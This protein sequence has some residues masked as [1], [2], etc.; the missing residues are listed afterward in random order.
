MSFSSPKSRWY[1]LRRTTYRSPCGSR[2]RCEVTKPSAWTVYAIP[3][4]ARRT[5]TTTVRR[6]RRLDAHTIAASERPI[7]V[8]T[9]GGDWP[10]QSTVRGARHVPPRAGV[11]ATDHFFAGADFLSFD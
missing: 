11:L 3:A 4:A 6:G 8:R 9:C 2:R 5:D 1:S 7:T 10:E